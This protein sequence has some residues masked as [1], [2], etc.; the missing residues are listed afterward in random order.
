MAQP[1]R[2]HAID[3]NADMT[4]W[5]PAHHD[6]TA[7]IIDG[8]DAWKGLDGSERVHR[9]AAM[10]A[11][12]IVSLEAHF[13]RDASIRPRGCRVDDGDE[14]LV[15][16]R[17]QKQ[18]HHDGRGAAVIDRHR[19]ASLLISGGR[20]GHH[21]RAFRKLRNDELP[22]NVSARLFQVP[23]NLDMHAWQRSSRPGIHDLS[24]K[25]TTLF[26]AFFS[27]CRG[28]NDLKRP[29]RSFTNRQTMRYQQLFEPL[30]CGLCTWLGGHAKVRLN[31]RG[32]KDDSQSAALQL[33]EHVREKSSF[34]RSRFL[35]K[36]R[37]CRQR[38]E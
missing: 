36:D 26:L 4:E 8:R 7:E 28:L 20:R 25:G 29:A 12:E 27:R 5:A 16:A 31:D 37:E 9:H 14:L 3:H 38:R 10:E 2:R 13:R 22:G 24:F 33:L 34:V 6:I 35:C 23:V 17:V 30:P 18:T 19:A 1:R 15:S 32:G 21:S 11:I